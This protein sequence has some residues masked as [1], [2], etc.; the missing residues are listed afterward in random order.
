VSSTLKVV[1]AREVVA[2]GLGGGLES[3]SRGGRR[4]SRG[5]LGSVAL[6]LLGYVLLLGNQVV[7]TFFELHLI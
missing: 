1:L 2:H 5:V 7:N 3:E 6:G 4:H